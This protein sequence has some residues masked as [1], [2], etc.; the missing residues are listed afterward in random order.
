MGKSNKFFKRSNKFMVKRIM[1]CPECG[2]SHHLPYCNEDNILKELKERKYKMEHYL[3]AVRDNLGE[4][5]ALLCKG[6]SELGNLLNHLDANKYNIENISAISNLSFDIK[7]FC[8]KEE[9]EIGNK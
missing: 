6:R 9:L 4:L 5:H 3:V 2:S 7:N 8:K 1:H